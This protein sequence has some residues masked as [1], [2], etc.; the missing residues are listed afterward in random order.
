[1]SINLATWPMPYPV[2][3]PFSTR[4]PRSALTFCVRYRTRRSRARKN[5]ALART[6]WFF[7][8][9]NCPSLCWASNRARQ[10]R[11]WCVQRRN[12]GGDA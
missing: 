12:R 7:A 8:A 11:R 5:V 3:S 10:A 4:W 2:I 1:M 9:T 6:A